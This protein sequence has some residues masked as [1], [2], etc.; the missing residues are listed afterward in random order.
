MILVAQTTQCSQKALIHARPEERFI[1]FEGVAAPNV[2]NFDGS[3]GD[4]A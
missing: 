3:G 2:I 1:D 4:A